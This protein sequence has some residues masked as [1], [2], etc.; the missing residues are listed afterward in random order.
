MAVGTRILGVVQMEGDKTEATM[1]KGQLVILLGKD[2]SVFVS[3]SVVGVCFL[4]LYNCYSVYGEW[5]CNCDLSLP[6]EILLFEVLS[7]SFKSTF[8]C[9]SYI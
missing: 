4:I 9:F 3:D 2:Y 7:L 5:I 8:S 1:G 6:L